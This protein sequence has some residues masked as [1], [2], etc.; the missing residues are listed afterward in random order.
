VAAGKILL[1][2]VKL[3]EIM[4]RYMFGKYQIEHTLDHQSEIPETTFEVDEDIESD[5]SFV[6]AYVSETPL[7]FNATVI[8]ELKGTVFGI[9]GVE[10]EIA[11]I[12]KHRTSFESFIKFFSIIAE[13]FDE[14]A[15]LTTF[16]EIINA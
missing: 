16:S 4:I 14:G 6:D 1:P 12:P 5:F 8:D 9:S 2:N 13:N 10:N 3:S 11:L 7:I 15:E